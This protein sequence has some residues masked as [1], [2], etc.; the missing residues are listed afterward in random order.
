M[1]DTLE[2]CPYLDGRTARMP[3]RYQVQGAQGSRLDALLAAGDRRVGRMMYRTRCPDCSECKAIRIPIDRFAPSKSQRRAARKNEDVV[4]SWHEPQVTEQH[5][6]LYNTHK[7]QRNL[8]R[9]EEGL[10]PAGYFH[11]LVNTC[12]DTREAR[13]WVDGRLVGVGI[14][15]FGLKSSSSVY[16]YFD[17]A[18]SKRSLGVF[19]VLKEIEYAGSLGCDWHYLGLYV[20]E[21]DALNYKAQY[22]AHERLIDGVWQGFTREAR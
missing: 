10:T 7:R 17:P 1:H 21:C 5:L 8:A 6:A 2:T 22:F 11:W 13:Y 3:L 4:V 9:N 20:A 18:E 15:D 12:T 14:V 19:S 16:F